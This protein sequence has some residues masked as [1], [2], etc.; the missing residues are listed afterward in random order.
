[1]IKYLNSINLV[2]VT[3]VGGLC[4][5]QWLQEKEYGRR[6]SDLDHTATVQATKI[7]EQTE[8]IR[9]ATDDIGGFKTE[10][11]AFKTQVDELN[12]SVRQQKAQVFT[13]NGEKQKLARQ[14]ANLQ[15]ALDEYK[16]AIAGRD[17][18]IKTLLDQ[19]EQLVTANKDVAGKANQA[20]IAYNDLNTKYEDVVNRYNTLAVRYKA[21]HE[22]ADAK[23][24]QTK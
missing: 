5:F 8:S 13:L 17:D 9:Q 7:A 19:R 18:N 11:T 12:A 20:I 6:I 24:K 14:S 1:M 22:A 2:L 16:K 10:I 15:Q 21:E 3:L 23:D 4:V